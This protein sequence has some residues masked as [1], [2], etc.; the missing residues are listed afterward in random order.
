[1][2]ILYDNLNQS[3]IDKLRNIS[4]IVLDFDGV[5]TDNKV[6]QDKNGKESVRRSREDSLAIDLLYEAGLYD[7]KNYKKLDHEVDIIILSR[8]SNVIVKSVS[9]KIKVKCRTSIVKK[10]D[11]LLEEV[12]VRNLDLKNVLFIGNDLNDLECIKIVGVGVAVAD[13]CQQVIR[14]ADYVTSK[15]GGNGAFREVCELILYARN[16]HP[17]P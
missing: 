7:K 2:K 16:V 17:F 15:N 11:V 12:K 14:I 9:E 3:L 8:E 6:I 1:M 4:L 13:S 5:L 10:K